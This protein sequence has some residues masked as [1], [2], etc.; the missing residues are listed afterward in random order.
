MVRSL[1]PVP[2]TP[3]SLPSRQHDRRVH[4]VA[5]IV[6]GAQQVGMTSVEVPIGHAVVEQDPGAASHH[7]RT[8][9][10]VD[11]LYAADGVAV[12]VSGAEIG[13]VAYPG[14]RWR[15]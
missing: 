10:A 12:P 11:A 6:A 5:A 9:R 4:R 8:P 13:R 7:S 1:G 15:R 3:H 2:K 14:K